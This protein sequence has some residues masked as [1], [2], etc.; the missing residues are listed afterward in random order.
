MYVSP[1]IG[2]PVLLLGGIVAVSCFSKPQDR[3]APLVSIILPAPVYD[4]LAQ[5]AKRHPGADGQPQ[6]VE[7]FIEA[8]AR[9]R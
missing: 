9:H 5:R 1:L 2:V 3:A 7:Q 6:T 8:F 4:L